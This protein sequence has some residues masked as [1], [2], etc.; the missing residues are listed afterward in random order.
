MDLSVRTHLD[1]SSDEP[2]TRGRLLRR[3]EVARQQLSLR[4]RGLPGGFAGYDVLQTTP[5]LPASGSVVFEARL[6]EWSARSH[7][8]ELTAVHEQSGTV[9]L[10]GHGRTLECRTASTPTDTARPL[11]VTGA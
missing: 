11:E 8:V 9:L 6:V 2:L 5:E 7:V 3:L 10:Q 4:W 1:I